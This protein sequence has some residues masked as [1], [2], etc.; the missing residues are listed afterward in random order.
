MTEPYRE[1]AAPQP[2]ALT[3]EQTFNV[4]ARVGVYKAQLF[5]ALDSLNRGYVD[6]AVRKLECV[7]D[8]DLDRTN[9]EFD[10]T[11]AVLWLKQLTFDDIREMKKRPKTTHK[12]TGQ[13]SIVKT[14]TTLVE[15]ML[16]VAVAGIALIGT[17]CIAARVLR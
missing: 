10:V 14:Q 9:D 12:T 5:D 4:L 6:D 11:A 15:M 16:Y 17:I 2:V 7:K 8:V 1:N 3:L 13:V